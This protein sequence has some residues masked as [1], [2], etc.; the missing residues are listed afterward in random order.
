MSVGTSA[1][2]A[3]YPIAASSAQARA[4][5][6]VDLSTSVPDSQYGM[7]LTASRGPEDVMRRCF[8]PVGC[9]GWLRA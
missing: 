1:L 3:V 7:G 5:F 2:T 6:A 9:A 8:F 4:R